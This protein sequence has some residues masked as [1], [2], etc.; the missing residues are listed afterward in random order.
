MLKG[1]IWLYSAR[2]SGDRLIGI[3][4]DQQTHTHTHIHT[5]VTV[6]LPRHLVKHYSEF[7]Y[8]D[9]SG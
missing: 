1:I 8:E 5:R 6:K 7:V 9:V 2:L 3:Y 4:R